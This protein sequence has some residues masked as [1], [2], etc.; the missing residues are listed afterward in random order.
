LDKQ[1]K[2]TTGKIEQ[3]LLQALQVTILT[4]FNLYS[5]FCSLVVKAGRHN[6]QLTASFYYEE[7][8]IMSDEEFDNLKE[9]RTK[10]GRKRC[11]N[12][13][14]KGLMVDGKWRR[15]LQHAKVFNK[16][17]YAPDPIR[18]EITMLPF[19]ISPLLAHQ[20]RGC[21]FKVLDNILWPRSF[22]PQGRIENWMF[23]RK[24]AKKIMHGGVI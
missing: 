19:S 18:P 7:K 10:V 16:I 4:I 11:Q 3:E 9:D 20:L 5:Q 8:A 2:K 1:E 23:S 15:K 17:D 12:A 6:T 22:M 13:K 24:W 14:L 21:G